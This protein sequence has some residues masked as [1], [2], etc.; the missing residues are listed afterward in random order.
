MFHR[1]RLL[2]SLIILLFFSTIAHAQ[3]EVGSI[4][5]AVTDPTGASIADASVEA[6]ESA[7]NVSRKTTTSSTGQYGFLGLRPGTYVITVKQTGFADQSHTVTLAV[8]QRLEENVAMTVGTASQTVDVNTSTNTIETGSSELGNVRSEKQVQDLPLNSRN[9]TQLVYL[10]PGVNNRGNSANSVSQGYTNGRGTNGAVIGGNPPEDTVYLLDGIQSMDNDADDIVV[11]PS[12]DAIQEFKVQTSAAPASYG[13]SP[14]II[15]VSYRSG[16]ND[17]HGT[18]YEF[19]RN[20]AF[21]AKNYFDSHTNPI[22]PFHMNQYGANLSGPIVIPHLIH[23]K[24]KLFFFI[25]Y[26][27]KRQNQAQTY[28]STVPTAAFRR[29]DF[30]ALPQQL[31]VPGTAGTTKTP[32]LGNQLTTIDPTSA[33]LA[34]LYPLPNQPGISNNYLFNGPI[35]NDIQ[36][37]DARVDYHSDKA[38]IFGRFTKENP[39]TVSPGYLPAPAIG[40]GPS[41][42]GLTVIPAWQGVLG[43]SRSFGTNMFYEARLGYS[44]LNELLI[45][46]DSTKG[47]IAE[48]LGI[49]NANASGTGLTN[50]SISGGTVGLGDG[51]GNINKVNNNWEVDQAFTVTKKNHE[52]KVGVDYQSRRFAFFSPTYPVG[53][54]VFTGAYTGYGFADFLAGRPISSELDVNQFFSLLRFQTSFYVQDNWR[55]TDRL[56]LNYGLRDDTVT[57]WK[58]RSN[59]LAGF[60]PLN[61]GQLIPVGTAPFTGDS[62]TSGRYTNFGPRF[63]FAYSIDQKTVLRGGMGI[64]YA[65]ENDASNL[66]QAVNAPFHGSL[67]QNNSSTD[68]AAALPIS[69]GFP[70]A[71]PA[72]YPTAGTNFVY[73]PKS[74]KNPSATEF[75]LNIQRQLSSR[76]VLSIAYVGQV[77]VH[78]LATPNINLALPGPGAVAARRPFPNLADGT[79]LCPCGNSSYNS[80]QASYIYTS[81]RGLH[82]QGGYTYSH[83]LDDTS[84]TG[85]L[86]AMQNPYNYASYYGNS[87]FDL[88]HSLVLSQT[89]DLP[90]GKGK[91][92]FNHGEIVDLVAGGWQ[93]NSIDTFQTG[94]PFTPTMAT[95]QLNNGT[96]VQYPNR[97]GSGKIA[98]PGPHAWFNTADF[99]SPGLYT[100]G[101][102]GRNI[103]YGPGTKQVDFS[104]FKTI[105][106]N[107]SLTRYL[108]LRG[109][110]FNVL[111]T[112]QFNNPNAQIGGTTAGTI[113]SAGQPI[114]FQRT[115]REIQIAAKLYF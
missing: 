62:V 99:V 8:S 87:D 13:G 103:L 36:Q 90:F 101:N 65:F 97:L 78:V 82:L 45:D 60:S 81:P 61:G 92:F 107:E 29:G 44:R 18:L 53:Q 40:G 76:D 57:P 22:P 58:E 56:T 86:V 115:S 7:T 104:V 93:L 4:V 34:A 41:R 28:V 39:N 16:T 77:G 46:T 66:N 98:H 102:S 108:Q 21:D 105:H 89:Y 72:L 6:V 42:P 54:M 112:P 43:Y 5:G 91:Q 100:F 14:A 25:D 73:Y 31:Y 12:V 84:G 55:V 106:F 48:Q 2:L 33:N 19:L 27:G 96:G 64:F 83:S 109:E 47:D 15:N 85:N 59:R 52:I 1:M 94:S 9:F 26:E 11:F 3:F 23:G 32:L 114:L 71:R 80:L 51:S 69:A 88:R 67:V 68:Y 70:A 111:N 110:A 74:Y 49:P 37:G 75:N 20:S 79:A 10:A 35:I 113:S 24:N 30:S 50:I 95:S 17:L 38:S 63:G